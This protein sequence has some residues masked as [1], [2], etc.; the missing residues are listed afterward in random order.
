MG[1]LLRETTFPIKTAIFRTYTPFSDTSMSELLV[2]IQ[3]INCRQCVHC[4][5]K[6]MET[7]TRRKS[8]LFG[9]NW[10]SHALS[11]RMFQY[12]PSGNQQHGNWKHGSW[13]THP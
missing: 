13:D 3:V 10:S 8:R 11:L 7:R 6:K 9:E 5:V 1:F 12:T 4:M 2:S